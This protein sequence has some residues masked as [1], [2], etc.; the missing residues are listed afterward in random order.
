MRSALA[1]CGALGFGN[2]AGAL[3]VA[4]KA[5]AFKLCEQVVILGCKR[6]AFDR[7]HMHGFLEP[8]TPCCCLVST[9]HRYHR[10]SQ[11][12]ALGEQKRIPL[13]QFHCTF[14]PRVETRQNT[15]H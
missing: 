8:F 14:F 5:L 15:T 11:L 13:V 4:A 10:R 12:T 1:P 3:L 6:I 9:G 7:L 2:D